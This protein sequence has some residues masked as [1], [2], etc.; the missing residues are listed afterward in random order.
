MAVNSEQTTSEANVSRVEISTG[1]RL[2]FGLT[3]TAAPFGGIGVMIRD[4]GVRVVVQRNDEMLVDDADRLLP[5]VQR[6]RLLAG[7]AQLPPCRISILSQPPS[8]SGLGSGTQLCMSVA[9]ALCRFWGLS[10]SPLTLACELADRGKRSAVGVHG[11]FHGGVIYEG[12]DGLLLPNDDRISEPVSVSE[13]GSDSVP[14]RRLLNNVRSRVELPDQWRVALFVPEIPVAKVSGNAEVQ[15]FS[16]V[17]AASPDQR[18]RLQRIIS[19]EIL[20]AV[21]RCDFAEFAGAVHHYN[22]D[23]G[24]LFQAVQGG[25]YNGAPTADLV[26]SLVARGARGVGQSSWGPGVFAWFESPAEAEEFLSADGCPVPVFVSQPLSGP[27]SV[28][29]EST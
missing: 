22:Y 23:S 25:P 1:A 5:I 3:D 19:E 10:V 26:R 16:D 14:A 2:H 6:I 17:G 27:R 21:E 8:H 28:T 7:D 29:V 15:Q 20:V 11:Y 9:E 18:D 24:M 4:P 13:P 12:H